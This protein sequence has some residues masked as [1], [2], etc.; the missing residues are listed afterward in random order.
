MQV[1]ESTI[2]KRGSGA[3]RAPQSVVSASAAHEHAHGLI[4]DAPALA[5]V[6]SG[7]AG[8]PQP[9]TLRRNSCSVRHH[10]RVDSRA[11]GGA[12]GVVRSATCLSRPILLAI[13]A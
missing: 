10:A 5:M 4:G 2:A 3:Q 7:R 11:A 13:V 1:V 6:G 8:A 9:K 12:N